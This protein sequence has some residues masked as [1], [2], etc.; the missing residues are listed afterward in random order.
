MNLAFR[1]QEIRRA[2]KTPPELSQLGRDLQVSP[3]P[4]SKPEIRHLKPETR[5]PNK[6]EIRNQKPKNKAGNPKSETRNPKPET[7]E[8][9]P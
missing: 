9:K 4:N 1:P 5:K 6:T 3:N 8:L 7:S 2:V